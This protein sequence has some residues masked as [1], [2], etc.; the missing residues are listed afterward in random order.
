MFFSVSQKFFIFAKLQNCCI[1]D[2]V[3]NKPNIKEA[4]FGM[5]G[6]RKEI[7]GKVSVGKTVDGGVS[8]KDIKQIEK[9]SIRPVITGETK[10]LPPIMGEVSTKPTINE[11][12]VDRGVIYKDNNN[13]DEIGVFN[14]NNDNNDN[15]FS[16]EFKAYHGR[17]ARLPKR[18]E[19]TN[20]KAFGKSVSGYIGYGNDAYSGRNIFNG[21]NNGY[22]FQRSISGNNS[23][24][25]FNLKESGSNVGI[26][27]TNDHNQQD[28]NIEMQT[29]QYDP[30]V[31]NIRYRAPIINTNVNPPIYNTQN[32]MSE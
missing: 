14:G 1:I 32:F 15:N 5:G 18:S 3:I 12:P 27:M 31:S 26:S 20:M 23:F 9:T 29:V 17:N 16:G 22:G 28:N 19:E 2:T 24:G 13:D 8:V 7:S 4:E 6:V 11:A 21:E 10:I 25:R 30:V